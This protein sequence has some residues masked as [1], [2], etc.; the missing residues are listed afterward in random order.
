MYKPLPNTV[1]ISH[2]SIEGL[3]LIC[4]KDIPKF[5]NLGLFH[6]RVEEEIIR[7]P[8]SGFTNHSDEPNCTKVQ[9]DKNRWEL[10]TLKDI[11]VGEELTI[12][13]SLYKPN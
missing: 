12:K 9:P 7:T 1:T 13:Y 5:T 10:I 4:I 2:S 8:L 11:K 3:G 6:I